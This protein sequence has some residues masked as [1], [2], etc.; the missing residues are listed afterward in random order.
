MKVDIDCVISDGKAEIS[1]SLFDRVSRP[2]FEEYAGMLRR[3][4]FEYDSYTKSNVF[5]TESPSML[6]AMLKFLDKEFEISAMLKGKERYTWDERDKF[7]QDFKASLYEEEKSA[8]EKEPEKEKEPEEKESKTK[9]EPEEKE[10][11]KEK[12]PEEK[13]SKKEK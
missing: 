12:E 8:E 13:E 11:K 5:T 3:E 10:S 7:V 1:I 4:G 6:A 2:E 9:K